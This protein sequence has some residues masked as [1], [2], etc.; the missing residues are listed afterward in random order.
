MNDAGRV[1][2][3]MMSLHGRFAASDLDSNLGFL[4]FSLGLQHRLF[5]SMHLRLCS[6]L[7]GICPRLVRSNFVHVSFHAMGLK[8]APQ[9]SGLAL[10]DRCITASDHCI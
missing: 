1:C 7:C 5:I 4:G 2:E 9:I 6:E 8:V 3:L 10:A